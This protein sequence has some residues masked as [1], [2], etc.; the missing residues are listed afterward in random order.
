MT[1]A[2]KFLRIATDEKLAIFFKRCSSCT[3]FPPILY[4]C[5]SRNFD[6]C[7]DAWLDRLKEV[8][9][10]CPTL[11]VYKVDGKEVSVKEFIE[12][13]Y[14]YTI[15]GKEVSAKEFIEHFKKLFEGGGKP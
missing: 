1:V 5:K 7:K 10:G 13:C 2:D 4:K 12:S 14:V 11:Y 9:E 3:F 15:D 8:D 6:N